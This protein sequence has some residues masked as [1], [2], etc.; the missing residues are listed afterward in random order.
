M[1]RIAATT[2]V[3]TALLIAVAVVIASGSHT[4]LYRFDADAS[5]DALG[6]SVGGAG[7]VNADGYDDLIAGA[8]LYNNKGGTCSGRAK[9]YSGKD[10]STLHTFTGNNGDW[11]GWSVSGAGDVNNDGYADVVVGG[12]SAANG[13]GCVRVFSGKNGSKLLDYGGSTGAGHGFTVSGAGDVNLDGYD[14][15]IAGTQFTGT[16]YVYSGKDGKTL[17][18]FSGS[19][20]YSVSGAGD[21]NNDGYP[22]LIVG[23]RGSG[24]ATVFSGKDGSKLHTF[25]GMSSGG[26]FGHCVSG[27]GDV[28]ADGYDDL[29][30]GEWK[31]SSNTGTARVFSGKD[32]KALYTLY[33]DSTGDQFGKSVSGAGDVNGDGYDD[34]IIAAFLDDNNGG[35]SGSVRVFSGKD[36][37]TLYTLNGGV[38]GDCFGR[39]VSDAG[40]VN[41][42]GQADF[43]V[44]AYLAYGKGSAYVYA[45]PA[46]EGS[47]EIS[48]GD[49]ATRFTSVTLALT[50]RAVGPPVG[51]M[52]LRN[53]GDDWGAWTPVAATRNWTLTTGEGVKTVEVQFRSEDG[54]TS[55]VLSDSIILDQTPPIGS[56]RI[57][58]GA[59]TAPDPWVTLQLEY[60]DLQSGVTDVRFRNEGASWSLWKYVE[61]TKSW[62]ITPTEG[63]RTVE[64]QFRDAA[65][66]LSDVTA[67]SIEYI[68]DTLPPRVTTV[69]ICDNW[70]YICPE[71]KFRVLVHALDNGGGS[72]LDA[73]RVRVTGAGTWSEWFSYAGGPTVTLPRP[74]R[75]GLIAVK[76]MARD[77]MAN[78][79]GY[80]DAS[81]YLLRTDPP[82]LGSGAKAAGSL[83]AMW[84]VDAVALDLVAGDSLS[85][86]VTTRASEDKTELSLDVDVVSPEGKRYLIGRYPEDAKS[87]G[88]TGWVVPETR[89]YLV[90]VRSSRDNKQLGTYKLK[91]KVKQA[92]ANKKG[93][94]DFTGTE[95]TFD[96]VAGSKFKASLK[97]EGIE[98]AGV[99]LIGPGGP[100]A[101]ETSGKPG[102]VKIKRVV[103]NTG[104][105]TYVIRLASPATVAA[106]WSVRLPKLKGT[107]VE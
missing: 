3:A 25:S 4:T 29:V 28:N 6:L 62:T 13:A 55:A 11:F 104:T 73:F 69:R 72:G 43:I 83:S 54:L 70:H 34:V 46:P 98:P 49:A 59:D 32:G 68:P 80:E 7:D 65:G 17:Y 14:D 15:V 101:I 64:A 56:I 94:G 16:A 77:R 97:G 93:I 75:V 78:E 81:V 63:M 2:L 44:G 88:V 8:P 38:A 79:S 12:H 48:D 51:E 41:G 60:T 52:R 95:I 89:R 53:V 50:W 85:V 106:K 36:G 105:G 5:G 67:D 1:G 24:Q 74:E 107:V 30:V 103:L 91:A 19:G 35:N 27:A 102:K 57:D 37:K 21:V 100:V 20:S 26:Y 58:F 66:N 40:D 86:K 61:S 33:G 82:W 90:V 96:A 45:S 99:A 23:N 22:D 76:A 9:V 47:V 31:Y 87:M 10:G 18:T 71:E 92:K 42:N 39:S 84:D